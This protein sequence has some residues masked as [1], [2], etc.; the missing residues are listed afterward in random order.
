MKKPCLPGVAVA[1][2]LSVSA[3]AHDTRPYEFQWA[4]RTHDD[5]E[6]VVAL[7]DAEGWAVET[8]NAVASVASVTD[9]SLFGKGVM[10]LTYRATGANPVVRLKS[11]RPVALKAFDTL[12]LWVYGNNVYYMRPPRPPSTDLFADFRDAAGKP[13]SVKILNIHHLEWFL[14]QQRLNAAQIAR[15][16]DGAVFTGFTLAGGTNDKDAA[17]DFTSFCA[18]VEE[19]RPIAAKP[20]PKRP[21]RIFADAPAGIN[22]GDGTLPFPNR[23][24][25]VIPSANP[26]ARRLDYRLPAD[27]GNWDDLAFRADGV[28]GKPFWQR[29]ALGGGIWFAAEKADGQPVRAPGVFSVVTNS[30]APLDVTY[31][32]AFAAPGGREAPATVRFHVEGQSLAIDLKVGGD[33]VASVRFGGWEKPRNPRLVPM[34]FYN[35][36]GYATGPWH[37]PQVLVTDTP[38]G[39]LFHL[40]T[41]DWTQSNA[42]Q[43]YCDPGKLDV[44]P[45]SNGGTRY[46]PRTDGVRNSCVERFVYSFS[47]EFA[48]VL[49]EIPNP[50][51]P[52]KHV[53]G[54]VVWRSYGA[55]DRAKNA[56]HWR[57]VRARGLKHILVT[58]HEVGW[59]D[60]N[61]SYTFRTRPAPKKGGD[62]GQY[63]YARVM[64]DELGFHY[65]PYNNFTDF[66]PINGHWSPDRVSR[67][68]D[69]QLQTAWN[70]CYAPKPTYGVE[71]CETLTPIIQGKFDFNTA[72]CDV[73]TC[74]APWQRT[75]YDARIPGGG[76]FANTFYTFGEIMLIQRR[77]W[78]GPVYSEGAVHYMY[79]GLD[80]GN[81]GQD[82]GYRPAENPWLVDF[83]LRRIHPLG[84]NF[85][86]GAP[87]MFYPNGSRPKDRAVAVDRFLA[88]TVAFGHPG[89]L[90]M[91]GDED[92]DRSYFMLQQL[93]ARYTMADAKDIF[94]LEAD[95]TPHGTSAAVAFGIFR[96]SQVV[97]RYTDGT[98]TAVNGSTNETMRIDGKLLGDDSVSSLWL[99]PNGYFGRTGDGKVL[100]Y[101]G[102]VDGHRIDY[103]ASP[104]YVYLDARGVRTEMPGLT[105]ERAAVRLAEKGELAEPVVCRLSDFA[106]RTAPGE[107]TDFTEDF[108]VFCNP[109]QG[110]S[111]MGYGSNYEKNR[112]V[113]NIGQ[114]YDR[115]SWR[116]FEPREGEYDWKRLD[117]MIAYAAA[118]G[119][120]TSFR[121]MCVC[122]GSERPCTPDWVWEK[123]AKFDEWEQI[124]Y[125]GH[126]TTNR[127]PVFDDPVFL[128]CHRRFVEEMARRYDGDPRLAGI[129]LGSYGNFGEWHCHGLPPNAPPRLVTDGTG[130]KVRD[131]KRK[132]VPPRVYPFEIR[133]QYVDMYLRNFRKT[134]VVFMTDDWECLRYAL[135]DGAVPGVG[136]RRDGVGSPGHF[137]RWIGTKPYDA[138]PRMGEVWKD[139]PIWFEFYGGLKGNIL[140]HGWDLP[141]S[142]DWTLT[143]H[144][145]VVNT[146]PGNPAALVGDGVHYPLLAHIDRY[147]GA[148]LVPLRRRVVRS[149]GKISIALAGVNRGAAPIHLPYALE[150]AVVDEAGKTLVK[151]TAKADPTK[152]L[153]GPFSCEE[154][155]DLPAGVSGRLVARLVHRD[156]IFLDFRFA[157]RESLADRSLPL[158]AIRE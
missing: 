151:W 23:A 99:P 116:D 119:L 75:D 142:I 25:T 136:L 74:L 29:F 72:Y 7:E 44:A 131:A 58:D 40:A 97:T 134:P 49:P 4:N 84:C 62:K 86:M 64:I 90:V 26:S 127:A 81:Y 31:T 121:I 88:A 145:S 132:Y 15:A 57:R 130:R 51:S 79:T 39:P 41:M 24:L 55:T 98:V 143:N 103:A 102:L 78:R 87:D 110:W 73:H 150:F 129:D 82:Q 135:G 17:L 12:S 54:S 68:A 106:A 53:T 61:E 14:A 118:R 19:F 3:A 1:A 66:A 153:P 70:R 77:N 9:R 21:N 111:T 126:V 137:A 20:R 48:D 149:D 154:T 22:T 104:E 100:V 13:F 63:D 133:K 2:L 43:G 152:W 50:V 67:N 71:A 112:K 18:F 52:W 46:L 139:R 69:L 36:N 96:R 28:N 59:R 113:V 109:G 10:R 124:S 155:F 125:A 138:V 140:A 85:G 45:A 156:G 65:G 101:S 35:Y 30:A 144:V 83:D 32:G 122:S 123:G 114:V 6:P 107:R 158:G 37:R 157:A 27:P 141:Y 92:M 148:R 56:A 42:S 117:G 33:R 94:Y 95:G 34:P 105:A 146:C 76:T 120:P 80:D 38:E 108:D 8:S 128:D 60:G 115:P 5:H 11:P 47:G 147:A 93:A 91:E 16:A 89:F